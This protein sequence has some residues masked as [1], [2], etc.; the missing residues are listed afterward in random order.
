MNNGGRN[1]KSP[2]HQSVLFIT[3]TRDGNPNPTTFLDPERIQIRELRIQIV[4]FT[5]F[6]AF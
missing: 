3:K 2:V 6:V 1:F 4:N 5:T